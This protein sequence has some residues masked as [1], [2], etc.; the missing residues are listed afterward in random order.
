MKRKNIFIALAATIMLIVFGV[1]SFAQEMPKPGTVIDKS[2]YKKYAHLFP[3][4][5]LQGFEDGFGL[6]AP[7]SIQ[8]GETKAYPFPKKFM[9]LSAKNKGKYSVDKDGMIVGGWDRQGLP[10]PDLKKDDKDFVT[11]LMWNYD[12]RY[13]NDDQDEV[14]MPAITRRKGEKVKA[15]TT[16]IAWLRF[17]NRII[18]DPKPLYQ[19]PTKLKTAHYLHFTAPESMKNTITLDYRYI[20]LG[21]SDET[22][23]YLPSLRRIL[24]GEAGQRSTPIQSVCFSLDDMNIFDGRTV[25]FTY[26]LV[27]EQK[28]LACRNST[29]PE[30]IKKGS[31]PPTNVPSFAARTWDVVDTYVIDIFSK[32]PRYP[33][34]R[35]RVWMDK[36]NLHIYYGVVYDRAGKFWKFYEIAFTPMNVPGDNPFL[37]MQSHYALDAQFGFIAHSNGLDTIANVGLTYDQFTHAALLKMGR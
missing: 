37:L 8:V 26:K 13:E 5:A 29:L 9:E 15:T 32:N 23:I 7:Y 4:E 22:F 20:D 18:L 12:G 11:K 25:D 31:W 36:E 10:F 34:S 33:Q 1:I 30:D 3:P 6:H 24:R 28:V 16:H 19:T 35:K 2:N 14:R 21:K 17:T 27:G